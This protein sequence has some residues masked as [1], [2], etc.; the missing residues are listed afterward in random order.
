MSH[1]ANEVAETLEFEAANADL[2]WLDEAEKYLKQKHPRDW[3]E[4]NSVDKSS[5]HSGLL[6][7]LD[8]GKKR[9]DE[10]LELH[11]E[12]VPSLGL[13]WSHDSRN[14]L[15]YLPYKT[16]GWVT[17]KFSVKDEY[18][19]KLA[20]FDGI[21]TAEQFG[22]K[23][24][25]TIGKVL[26]A[27]RKFVKPFLSK[28]HCYF[29]KNLIG[30]KKSNV[31]KDQRN[32]ALGWLAKNPC[33]APRTSAAPAPARNMDAAPALHDNTLSPTNPPLM[34]GDRLNEEPR[35]PKRRRD[36]VEDTQNASTFVRRT[37]KR[38]R[39][40]ED[41]GAGPQAP[42]ISLPNAQ[43]DVLGV[44]M[45]TGSLLQNEPKLSGATEN[46]MMID[47][48]ISRSVSP[49]I[50]SAPSG[51]GM[52]STNHRITDTSNSKTAEKSVNELLKYALQRVEERC[53]EDLMKLKMHAASD[54]NSTELERFIRACEYGASRRPNCESYRR[55]VGEVIGW[56]LEAYVELISARKYDMSEIESIA[57][58]R[59]GSDPNEDEIWA[60]Q[61][62][63]LQTVNKCME[64]VK[65]RQDAVSALMAASDV[66]VLSG[67]CKEK[68]RQLFA[69]ELVYVQA[70][71][72]RGL[73][74]RGKQ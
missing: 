57:R 2:E 6:R 41:V 10:L 65:N 18:L 3:E 24:K 70:V 32:A 49:P 53:L 17:R 37:D 68:Q 69:E 54:S 40:N 13:E 8:L 16:A 34:Q 20:E 9:E 64:Y 26:D 11:D 60:Q 19:P 45:A 63:V 4:L 23:G 30:T 25:S 12:E 43:S 74:R 1:D 31:L 72:I 14:E 38:I 28:Y 61:Q 27:R 42:L 50:P 29:M 44:V 47:N 66:N 51:Y 62:M 35:T 67:K 58:R 33:G 52:N 7:L 36:S 21:G 56:V 48:P 71:Y 73:H 5:Q 55:I 22:E 15:V 39:P 46:A 59:G